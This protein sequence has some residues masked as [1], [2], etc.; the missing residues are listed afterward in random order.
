MRILFLSL[1]LCWTASGLLAQDLSKQ[2]IDDAIRAGVR[3]RI[4][5]LENYIAQIGDKENSNALRRDAIEAAVALFDDSQ[6][7]I[8]ETS[9][10]NRKKK[11][12]QSPLDY[13][14]SLRDL[15]YH[16]VKISFDNSQL[17]NI[18]PDGP[19]KHKIN[20]TIKQRFEARN[21]QDEVVYF[22]FTIKN[23]EVF[24]YEEKHIYQ[25]YY[26]IKLGNITVEETH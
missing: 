24:V 11:R 2:D 21:E 14:R 17:G 15:N 3:E 9:S 20:G 5:L 10:K 16:S 7:P 19:R 12:R 23:V 8:I 26:E 6:K 25:P 13:F 1:L 18:L 22:D 4:H